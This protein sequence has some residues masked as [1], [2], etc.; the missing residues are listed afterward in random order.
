[1]TRPSAKMHIAYPAAV[2]ADA[3]LVIAAGGDGTVGAVANRIANTQA[4]L[5]SLPL[6]T[7]NDFARSLGVPITIEGL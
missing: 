5:R 3:K 1:M 6:G 4:V 2:R 7:S